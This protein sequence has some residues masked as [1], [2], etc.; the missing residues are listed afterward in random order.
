MNTMYVYVCVS[1]SLSLS[2]S[3][4]PLSRIT[5][6]ASQYSHHCSRVTVTKSSIVVS[7]EKYPSRV[8]RMS[9]YPCATLWNRQEQAVKRQ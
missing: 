3:L 2:L 9:A 8:F 4:T 5:V 1:F 6:L 7:R